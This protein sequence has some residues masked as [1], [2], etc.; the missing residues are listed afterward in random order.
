MS[1]NETYT[2]ILVGKD[3]SDMVPI[4]NDQKQRCVTEISSQLYCTICHYKGSEKTEGLK[5]NGTHR[6]LIYT[7][8]VNLLPDS[9]QTTKKNTE[10]FIVTN[11]GIGLEIKTVEA[12]HIVLSHEH[13][14]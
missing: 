6:L 4:K 3:L 5:Q 11:Q 12:K 2:T 1:S 7:D 9:I 14:A 13:H 10:D 8:K